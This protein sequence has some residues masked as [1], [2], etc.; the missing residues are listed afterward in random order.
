[1][2]FYLSI[3]VALITVLLSYFFFHFSFSFF[4]LLSSLFVLSPPLL[5]QFVSQL[6]NIKIVWELLLLIDNKV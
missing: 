1:M 2:L 4:S 5:C 6:K 3:V